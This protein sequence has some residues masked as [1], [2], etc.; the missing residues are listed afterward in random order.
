MGFDW[1]NTQAEYAFF[2]ACKRHYGLSI[3]VWPTDDEVAT[4]CM[5]GEL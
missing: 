2:S 5:G 1:L 4:Y 3:H